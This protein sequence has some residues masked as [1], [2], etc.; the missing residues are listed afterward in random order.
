[1]MSK[2][3]ID[4]KYDSNNL[5]A[6]ERKVYEHQQAKI[7]RLDS[8]VGRY[9]ELFIE[10][11]QIAKMFELELETLYNKEGSMSVYSF[12]QRQRKYYNGL[13]DKK[14]TEIKRLKY[15]LELGGRM[16]EDSYQLILKIGKKNEML[17]KSGSSMSAEL[18]YQARLIKA[19]ETVVSKEEQ[20]KI[21]GFIFS[22]DDR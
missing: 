21:K 18:T 19:Y 5:S 4:E 10:W 17:E 1:M 7:D 14:D 9:K 11:E 22:E 13:F 2:Q 20:D 15:E 12:G 8:D 3:T 6:F 16:Y